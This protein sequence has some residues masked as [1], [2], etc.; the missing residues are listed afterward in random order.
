[1]AGFEAIDENLRATLAVF[2]RAKPAG[3]WC[4]LAGVAVTSSAVQFSMFNSAVLTAPVAS[5][6][7]L[8]RRIAVAAEFFG[9]RRLSWSFWTCQG[10]IAPGV[11]GVVA[12]VFYRRGLH[13]VTEMPGMEAEELRPPVRDL[14]YLELRRVEDTATRSDFSYVMSSAFGLPPPVAR[15]I[16]ESEGTWRAGLTGWVGYAAG[17]A[18]STT[19]TLTTDAAIGVYAVGT[20]PAHRR[21]GYA[22]AVM[23]HA[24]R[25]APARTSVLESSEAGLLL[26]R[27][28]G[29]RTVTRYAVFA[30]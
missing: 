1:M 9:Q 19:A 10:W 2:G 14:P 30:A 26:Y 28:L 8:D 6:R 12:D 21:R 20:P 11:R 27:A 22:Q 18:V 17:V 7:E 13:L 24:L 3:E 4:A 29:Y 5:A 15:D 16:Y 25:Q 23:R